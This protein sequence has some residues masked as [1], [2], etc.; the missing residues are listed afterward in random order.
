MRKI[1]GL[2]LIFIDF[3]IPAL[4]PRLNTV[5]VFDPASL[6]SL[7]ADPQKTPLLLLLG[8][9]SLLQRCVYRTVA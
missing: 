7:G 6:Y 8:V 9:D 3:Y 4:T 5:K 1:H 2:N